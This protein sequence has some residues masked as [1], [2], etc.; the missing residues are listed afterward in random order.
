MTI[1]VLAILYSCY[2]TVGVSMMLITK[3]QEMVTKWP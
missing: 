2:D 3:L 1:C